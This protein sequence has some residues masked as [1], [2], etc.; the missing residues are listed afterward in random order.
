MLVDAGWTLLKNV[1]SPTIVFITVLLPRHRHTSIVL[2]FCSSFFSF[3]MNSSTFGLPVIITLMMCAPC[4]ARISVEFLMT[5]SHLHIY[6]HPPESPI[7]PNRELGISMVAPHNHHHFPTHPWLSTLRDGLKHTSSY[8]SSLG[9]LKKPIVRRR[10]CLTE[11]CLDHGVACT[12][13]PSLAWTLYWTW[14]L[15][16]ICVIHSV[17]IHETSRKASWHRTECWVSICRWNT[18]VLQ[19]YTHPHRMNNVHV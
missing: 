12:S 9:E 16:T 17:S 1:V 2:Q 13:A 14:R 19:T 8:V 6:A 11:R 15:V 3:L 4:Y 18:T 5:P 7:Q 10:F